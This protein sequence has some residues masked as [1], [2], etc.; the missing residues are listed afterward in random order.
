MNEAYVCPLCL[1]S[2]MPMPDGDNAGCTYC[3]V[4]APLWYLRLRGIHECEREEQ[5][6]AFERLTSIPVI[7]ADGTSY[8]APIVPESTSESTRYGR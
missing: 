7:L 4:V 6:T 3:N 1:N 8:G 2:L 5:T